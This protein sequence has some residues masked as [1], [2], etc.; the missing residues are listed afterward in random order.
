MIP[1]A[2]ERL[3]NE[4][5]R[6]LVYCG[7]RRLLSYAAVSLHLWEVLVTAVG[8]SLSV[9]FGL[10]ALA[11]DSSPSKRLESRRLTPQQLI[12]FSCLN[13]R[14]ERKHRENSGFFR[15]LCWLLF[16]LVGRALFC[17][18]LVLD[19]ANDR[20]EDGSAYPATGDVAE[21]GGEIQRATASRCASQYALKEHPAETA[22]HNSGDGVP[23]CAQAI[24]FH[25]RA[26]DVAADCATDCFDD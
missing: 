19:D 16:G 17:R 11:R 22:A 20:H 9:A 1:G 24:F 5:G 26:G 25:C 23:C 14:W 4:F 18:H 3:A 13:F 7:R 15:S 8:S 12:L 6:R 21:Y 10:F 2:W